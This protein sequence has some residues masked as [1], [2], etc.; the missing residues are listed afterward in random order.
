M[1]SEIFGADYAGQFGSLV[2]LLS[3]DEQERIAA[4]SVFVDQICAM[5][6]A[7]G[8]EHEKAHFFCGEAEIDGEI[9]KFCAW[10]TGDPKSIPFPVL[11][12]L[13]FKG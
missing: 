1:S 5:L 2:I 10:R 9:R 3:L 4:K 11:D 13:T 8:V 6:G 12:T 7:A